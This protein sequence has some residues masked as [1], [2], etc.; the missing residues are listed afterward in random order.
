[1]DRKLS[2]VFSSHFSEEKNKKF[3]EHVTETAGNIDLHV[4][5]IPN[6]K[7]YSL[8]EA[9]NLGWKVI[10]DMG[11]GDGAIVFCHNDITFRTKDWGKILINMFVGSGYDILGVAGTTQLNS[12]GAWWIKPDSERR[13]NEDPMNRSKMFGRVWH[14]Q[15]VD[16]I[17]E[18]V[19]SK[20]INGV[21]QVVI[22]DGLFIA[23]NGKSKI[24]RYDEDFKGFH[25]YDISFCFRNYI[26]GYD[27]GVI[28]RISI[29]HQSQ[30]ATNNE[31]ELNRQQFVEK[32][33]EELPV[34]I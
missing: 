20:K 29:L 3:I 9:Y 12:H 10:D 24:E 27:I 33:K 31:W 1:M 34:T 25:F 15:G 23:V 16:R 13:E 18:S 4:H 26:E 14:P 28:D 5:C 22:V 17:E 2:V 11:R 7:H 21:Q 30:G 32:Y 19:Y 8:P 6:M